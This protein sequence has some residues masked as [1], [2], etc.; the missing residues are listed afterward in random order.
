MLAGKMKLRNFAIIA[1]GALVLLFLVSA[2]GLVGLSAILFQKTD[3]PPVIAPTTVA[4]TEVR[5]PEPA[6]PPSTLRSAPPSAPATP[7]AAIVADAARPWDAFLLGKVG[8]SLGGDKVKD[9]T[10]RTAYKVNLYQD[11][12]SSSMNR[13]KVDIDRDDKWDE[14]WTFKPG[15]ITREVAPADDENYTQTWLWVNG[16]WKAI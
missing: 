8:Q 13:A 9:A 12:G 4:T 11:A 16:A 1:V 5:A 10:G 15:E 14:K 3:E 7:E 2:V 6:P